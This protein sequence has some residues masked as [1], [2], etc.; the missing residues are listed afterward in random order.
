[1]RNR[2]TNDTFQ[3]KRGILE[4]KNKKEK[5]RRLKRESEE[6]TGGLGDKKKWKRVV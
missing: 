2:K 5:E 4:G 3:E 6:S 1:M